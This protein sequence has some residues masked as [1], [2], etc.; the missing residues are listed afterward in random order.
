[1]IE[2]CRERIAWMEQYLLPH[3]PDIRAWLRSKSVS[4]AEI[5]DIVQEMYARVGTVDDLESIHAPR[6]YAFHVARSILLNILRRPHIVSITAEGDLDKLGVASPDASPEEEMSLR[7]QLSEV[8][9]AIADLPQRTRDVLLLRRIEGLSQRETANRLEIAEKTVEKHLAR[10]AL[11]L[12][13][14]FGRGGKT[15]VRLSSM[16]G[17]CRK[18]AVNDVN[19]E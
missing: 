17:P 12:M 10:A 2:R 4:C 5:D 7:E 19:S 16:A 14:Q 18:H 9:N 15:G 1:M 8:L 6:G 13:N 11:A 3:E